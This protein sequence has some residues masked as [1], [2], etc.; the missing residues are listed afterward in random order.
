MRFLLS[1]SLL[2]TICYEF[3]DYME[4]EQKG[5]SMNLRNS[6]YFSVAFRRHQAET[7]H[8]AGE[9]I[10]NTLTGKATPADYRRNQDALAKENS[11]FQLPN[12]SVAPT[13]E[14]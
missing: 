13:L 14:S 4:T 10:Y 11:G 12:T 2:F 9:W 8:A 5:P 6:S 1:L 7:G 3:Y